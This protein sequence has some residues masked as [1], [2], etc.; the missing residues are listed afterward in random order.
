MPRAIRNA[1]IIAMQGSVKFALHSAEADGYVALRKC[2]GTE[3][4]YE[5]SPLVQ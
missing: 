2:S 3:L 5:N 4:V 1:I